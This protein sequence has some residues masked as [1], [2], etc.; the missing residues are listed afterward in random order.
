MSTGVSN[1]NNN[2]CTVGLILDTKNNVV[3]YLNHATTK[4]LDYVATP[5]HSPNALEESKT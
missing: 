2:H 1:Y 4:H 5:T 3:V